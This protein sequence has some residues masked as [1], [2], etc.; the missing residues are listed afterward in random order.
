MIRGK[1]PKDRSKWA[2]AD[3]KGRF[4]KAYG[5]EDGATNVLVFS[6][7]GLLRV[8]VTGRDVEPE[9]VQEIVDAVERSVD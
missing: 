2:L 5:Y 1:F 3:W 8:H 4:A 9:S 7:H 6:P